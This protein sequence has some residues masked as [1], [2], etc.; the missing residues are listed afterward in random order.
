MSES[1]RQR[2]WGDGTLYSLSLSLNVS[3][4]DGHINLIERERERP[5]GNWLGGE[6]E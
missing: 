5:R 3:V 4:C 2:L 6:S 1:N